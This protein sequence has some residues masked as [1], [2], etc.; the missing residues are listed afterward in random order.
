MTLKIHQG[1]NNDTRY[2][3]LK[4]KTKTKAKAKK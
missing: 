1:H 2:S 4:P 3:D